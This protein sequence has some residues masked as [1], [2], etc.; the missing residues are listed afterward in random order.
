MKREERL[1]LKPSKRKT[2]FFLMFSLALTAGGVWMR[3]DEPILGWSS[4]LFFGLCAIV[5]CLRL[6]P[7]ASYL[8]LEAEGFVIC[9]FFRVS[10]L[11][12]WNTIS[13][14]SAARLPNANT[15]FV[16]FDESNPRSLNL[17]KKNKAL[18][19]FTSA[20]PDTYGRSA[21]DL[22]NELNSWR[23]R[24]RDEKRISSAN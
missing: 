11:V 4:A 19:G 2:V 6:W 15:L 22:V 1:V 21:A 9:E 7:Q 3:M 10:R 23:G 16:V 20:L 8:K 18:F 12:E 5:F 14:F 13:E 17:A 24:N